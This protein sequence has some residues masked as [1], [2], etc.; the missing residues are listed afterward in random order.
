MLKEG[1]K[2]ALVSDAGLPGI[3]DP[4]YLVCRRA[5][6]A[7]FEVRALPGASAGITALVASGLPCDKFY[8]YG[9]LDHKKSQKI[10]ELNDLCDIKE[11]IINSKAKIMKDAEEIKRD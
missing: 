4:G 10:K 11:T 3:S 6:E 9:F 2:L 1:K 8:F 7:G 5:L